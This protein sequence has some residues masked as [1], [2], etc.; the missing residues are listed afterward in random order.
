MLFFR[1]EEM[2]EA[3]CRAHGVP[4]RPLVRLDQLWQ[5]AVAWYE[6]R[7]SPDARRPSSDEM[8]QIFA[9]VGLEEPF[10]DPKSDYFGSGR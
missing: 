3:W 10:W 1:S 4:K 5:M 2:V 8:R 9:R 6:N 7:L